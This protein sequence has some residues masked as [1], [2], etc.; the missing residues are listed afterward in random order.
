MNTKSHALHQDGC[1]ET[2]NTLFNMFGDCEDPILRGGDVMRTHLFR[3][4]F[5][6]LIIPSSD[7]DISNIPT[8]VLLQFR[9]VNTIVRVITHRP[10][11]IPLVFRHDTYPW[12][13]TGQRYA[14]I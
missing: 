8:I 10:L 5:R 6:Y 1:I 9:F 12:K 3:Y 13:D 11:S 2:T 7:P 4:L 14:L